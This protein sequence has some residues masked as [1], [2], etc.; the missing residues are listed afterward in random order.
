M[1]IGVRQAPPMPDLSVADCIDIAIA[2][3]G[4]LSAPG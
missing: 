1:I 4:L 3:A 2:P